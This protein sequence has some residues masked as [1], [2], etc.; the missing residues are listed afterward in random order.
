MISIWTCVFEVHVQVGVHSTVQPCQERC[1][2]LVSDSTLCFYV[3][4][5]C[6]VPTFQG[7]P[8]EILSKLADVLEEVCFPKRHADH[9]QLLSFSIK[10]LKTEICSLQTTITISCTTAQLE[11]SKQ[12]PDHKVLSL[13]IRFPFTCFQSAISLYTHASYSYTNVNHMKL[14]SL[15]SFP[16]R[17]QSTSAA[18]V[19]LEYERLEAWLVPY[20]FFPP[21]CD[22]P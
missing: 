20:S 16:S 18:A 15:T 2:L 9:T 4:P 8:E 19:I 22:S 3:S 1:V 21:V 13:K 6:S 12:K 14:G 17:T 10:I 5:S 11:V 7:L